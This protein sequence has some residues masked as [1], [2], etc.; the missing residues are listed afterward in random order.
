MRS[1][2]KLTDLCL[3]YLYTLP[4]PATQPSKFLKRNYDCSNT[5]E[6]PGKNSEGRDIV[7][8]HY[9][10]CLYAGITTSTDQ[11]RSH[12][13]SGI[14]S[15]TNNVSIFISPMNQNLQKFSTS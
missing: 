10:E 6:A 8:S 14:T 12:A 1:T 4:G 5:G 3:V 7:D 2:A 13:W 15:E 11:W 9:K